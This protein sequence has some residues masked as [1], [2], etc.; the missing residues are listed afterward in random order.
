MNIAEKA[1]EKK[2]PLDR[3]ETVRW[4]KGLFREAEK[5]DEDAQMLMTKREKEDGNGGGERG[6]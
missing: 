3:E 2:R 5:L 4:L 6:V 1:E